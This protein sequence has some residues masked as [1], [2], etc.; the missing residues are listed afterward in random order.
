MPASPLSQ[1]SKSFSANNTGMRSWISATKPLGLVMSMVQDRKL[2]AH[3]LRDLRAAR[4]LTRPL[5][6]YDSDGRLRA[7]IAA[8]I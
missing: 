8:T 3:L 7:H 1:G 6:H 4:C 5:L 2:L